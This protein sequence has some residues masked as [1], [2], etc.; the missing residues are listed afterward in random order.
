MNK[1]VTTCHILLL[2]FSV[3]FG[4]G[5]MTRAD[6]PRTFV[7]PSG[8]TATITTTPT[9][10]EAVGLQGR[11][12]IFAPTE[13]VLC[14]GAPGFDLQI[15]F[16]NGV[17]RGF[18]GDFWNLVFLETSALLDEKES[19]ELYELDGMGNVTG[20][21]LIGA[22]IFQ[23]NDIRKEHTKTFTPVGLGLYELRLRYSMTFPADATHPQ[24]TFVYE[25]SVRINNITK[26]G[27]PLED[28]V[29]I[30]NNNF[31]ALWSFENA[32]G[33][34]CGDTGNISFKNAP[35]TQLASTVNI[36]GTKFIL[37]T[38]IRLDA[39]DGTP[40][41]QV[42]FDIS[43]P[44]NVQFGNLTVGKKYTVTLISTINGDNTAGACR[45]PEISM[46]FYMP[47]AD[48]LATSM[49][50]LDPAQGRAITVN[51]NTS[52]LGILPSPP[53][54]AV[55]GTPTIYTRSSSWRFVDGSGAST[56]LGTPPDF[57]PIGNNQMLERTIEVSTATHNTYHLGG[58]GG[59]GAVTYLRGLLPLKCSQIHTQIINVIPNPSLTL[60]N[61]IGCLN[62]DLTFT[63][64]NI[65][66]AANVDTYIWQR[67]N[68]DGGINNQNTNTGQITYNP[69]SNTAGTSPF[70]LTVSGNYKVGGTLS[71][72][73]TWTSVGWA[74]PI[75][76]QT[77][78]NFNPTAGAN[79]NL[80]DP[81]TITVTLGERPNITLTTSS[82]C[83]MPGQ[84]IAFEAEN[85]NAGAV[86]TSYTWTFDG[87]NTPSLFTH[88][89]TST[90]TIDKVK[91]KFFSIE[92]PNN[93]VKVVANTAS[94]CAQ[95]VEQN[96][97]LIPNL[98]G[99]IELKNVLNTFFAC[100]GDMSQFV[101]DAKT[102]S[103]I[104]FPLNMPFHMLSSQ[105]INGTYTTI[106]GTNSTNTTANANS[107]TLSHAFTTSKESDA[108]YFFLKGEV[109]YPNCP[110][111]QTN[112][113]SLMVRP[114]LKHS[115][116]KDILNAC[117]PFEYELKDY[118]GFAYENAT[119]TWEYA[120]NNTFT[121][122]APLTN[123]HNFLAGITPTDY[124]I[125][126]TITD[127]AGLFDCVSETIAKITV[128]PTP[129]PNI[130]YTG[131]LVVT[132]ST[133]PYTKKVEINLGDNWQATNTVAGANTSWIL[134]G[135]DV[136]PV[137]INN[138]SY[139]FNTANTIGLHTLQTITKAGTCQAEQLD[140][141]VVSAV[142]IIPSF[143]PPPAS[144]AGV[145][146]NFTNTTTN[147]A[148]T[149]YTWDFG[150]GSQSITTDSPIAV[151]HT[152]ANGGNFVVKLQAFNGSTA[153]G[154]LSQNLTIN[155]K[156]TAG[157]NLAYPSATGAG[158]YPSLNGNELRLSD[159][160]ASSLLT[161]THTYVAGTNVQWNFDFDI[162]NPSAG[163]VTNN[164]ANLA[165]Q[166]VNNKKD[167]VIKQIVT[168][169]TTGCVAE[170]TKTVWVKNYLP[171]ADLTPV[172]T[173]ICNF[174]EAK[175]Q[176][177]SK[178]AKD[179]TWDFGDGNPN[180][181]YAAASTGS[182]IP[183]YYAIT[184][185]SFVNI[186]TTFVT[187]RSIRYNADESPN[188]EK[189]HTLSK[190]I[191]LHPTP[192]NLIT[193]TDY[194][195]Y[196]PNEVEVRVD[197]L[198]NVSKVV[199]DYDDGTVQTYHA[200]FT[201]FK[202]LYQNKLNPIIDNFQYTIKVRVYSLQ[203]CASNPSNLVVTV[204]DEAQTP[205]A[206]FEYP[207][208]M[209]YCAPVNFSP[210]NNSPFAS[211]FVWT[212][213]RKEQNGNYILLSTLLDRSPPISFTEAG[214][215][216]LTL[217]ACNRNNVCREQIAEAEIK[218]TAW[219]Y[220]EPVTNNP[221]LIEPVEF[222]NV[223]KGADELNGGSFEW[224]FGDGKP[225]LQSGP[226][227]IEPKVK[228]RFGEAKEYIIKLYAKNKHNCNGVPYQMKLKVGKPSTD[229]VRTFLFP[230]V[231]RP[232]QP[233]GKIPL[234]EDNA[235]DNTVFIPFSTVLPEEVLSYKLS[236]YDK[237]GELI[238][239]SREVYTGWDGTFRGKLL[240]QDVYIWA[241]EAVLSN[242]AKVQQAGDVLLLR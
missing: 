181:T 39:N 205:T 106:N 203:G 208:N 110:V 155:P 206:I 234:G 118:T 218:P 64:T 152:Y 157:F 126:A 72:I 239:I 102:G 148:V 123:G 86:V 23:G 84:E 187:M 199:I 73:P 51:D 54:I 180:P 40:S 105:R 82:L 210:H 134:D 2:S 179:N 68:A 226:T 57:L 66:G 70:T 178:Y 140:Q 224:N 167:I 221:R 183:N 71:T 137:P 27:S 56:N 168:N 21:N 79:P 11:N 171:V 128:N 135:I 32:P 117:A 173:D 175:F 120:N 235:K 48:F 217:N 194:V 55:V 46:T 169:T 164:N 132:N 142:P 13:I 212:V 182:L 20:L 213:E 109:N 225:W 49:C 61:V 81:Q 103:G 36:G 85:T 149:A 31:F 231:F 131:A 230:N 215:Y 33:K 229:V 222:I 236:I 189:I 184:D 195:V 162:N 201:T 47:R 4:Q 14:D 10:V 192:D 91:Y 129:V 29:W 166:Y 99:N 41:K 107:L 193:L 186:R 97:T 198:A 156:P 98:T 37:G 219:A 220:F 124:H 197:N 96:I 188:D 161:V 87:G 67:T 150:D 165:H 227:D 63:A 214:T 83:N 177:N 209:S 127:G 153:P 174:S 45:V 160:N 30:V 143:T 90:P 114:K 211:K 18:L 154:E 78:C 151:K 121:G 100:P 240:T 75:I 242:N 145:E 125:K 12:D 80:P 104:T 65:A 159:N 95:E 163:F 69:I 144:C 24:K 17:N 19:W 52:P 176:D 237:K 191:T 59:A 130:N 232:S 241:V 146:L 1:I 8:G 93:K 233:E 133:A 196:L 6:L 38:I 89:P 216:R 122:A 26:A 9:G 190:N 74:Y 111:F 141:I 112:P 94:G 138:W 5:E 34:W 22:T 43:K 202:H 15:S 42:P 115:E 16:K 35:E 44:L 172:N 228:H 25:R 207:S 116:V 101:I 77:I 50:E 88:D 223:S 53:N 204:V 238:F 28:P 147:P 200:P 119:V 158:V 136:T 92:T 58:A 113:L 170:E 108:E 3:L 60:N 76:N 62:T 7:L 139:P 185:P